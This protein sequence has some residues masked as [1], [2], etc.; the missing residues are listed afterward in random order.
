L[1]VLGDGG[2]RTLRAAGLVVAVT[3]PVP[4]QEIRVL[5]AGNAVLTVRKTGTG[6][7]RVESANKLS[8]SF[9]RRSDPVDVRIPATDPP[10]GNGD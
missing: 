5:R 9:R 6:I 2:E 7:L 8:A 3:G 10:A 4:E 1:R